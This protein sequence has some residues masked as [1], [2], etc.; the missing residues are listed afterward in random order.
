MNFNM[1]CQLCYFVTKCSGGLNIP[2]ME[3]CDTHNWMAPSK[4]VPFVNRFLLF[5]LCCFF[6]FQ[7]TKGTSSTVPA[8]DNWLYAPLLA[9]TVINRQVDIDLPCIY[10][11]WKMPLHLSR[12]WFHHPR[13]HR[14]YRLLLVELNYHLVDLHTWIQMNSAPTQLGRV[15]C[16]YTY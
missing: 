3:S 9:D 10:L 5:C 11:T 6:C 13:Y 7:K 2:Y 16:C 4:N 8:T 14:R 1:F 12:Q 15:M